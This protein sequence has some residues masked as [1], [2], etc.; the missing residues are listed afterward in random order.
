MR[1]VIPLAP[2][3][4]QNGDGDTKNDCERNASGRFLKRLRKDHPKAEFVITED[5]LSSN[6]PHIREIQSLG[7]NFIL[8]AKPGDH[9]HLFDWVDALDE[10][11]VRTVTGYSY[12]GKKV[13]RRTTQ[14]IRYVN[15]VPLNDSNE[16]LKVNFLELEET[17]EK[18][19]EKVERDERGIA[20]NIA[21]EWKKEKTTKFSWV[22]DIKISDENVF[23]IMRGG[24]KRWS[25]EN[26]TFN[27][28]KN[29]GYNWEH[30]YGHGEDNLATNFALL[31]MLAFAIDQVQELCCP[32]F[33]KTLEKLGN[34]RK[35]LWNKM[36]AFIYLPEHLSVPFNN[37]TELF[38]LIVYGSVVPDSS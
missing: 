24:R 6:A 25:I 26:E 12:K 38:G 9:K 18:R 20:K 29:M 14:R 34:T 22:T 32:L 11:E 17:V 8:G 5:G 21:Y 3:P 33:R 35:F 37:W 7:M 31:M 15:R 36:R 1:Q 19:I 16:D 28:L 27:G 4:I 13:I 23:E 30:N 10:N 2:E